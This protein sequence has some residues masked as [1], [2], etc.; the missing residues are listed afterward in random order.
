M[1]HLILA[2]VM[3]LPVSAQVYKCESEGKTTYSQVPCAE[4]AE[5]I[6]VKAAGPS[7]MAKSGDVEQACLNYLK[8]AKSWKD[9]DSVRVEGSYKTWDSDKSGARHI[10][11]IRLNAKNSYGAYGGAETFRCFLNHSGDALSTVQ[12]FIR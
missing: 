2:A 12:R 4:D 3:A 1:K 5:A 7:A 6:D 8:L 9:P 10:L 11:N